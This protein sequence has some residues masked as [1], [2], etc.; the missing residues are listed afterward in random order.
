MTEPPQRGLDQEKYLRPFRE[1]LTLARKKGEPI[2]ISEALSN[3][4]LAY[5]DLEE[6][7]QGAE[8]FDLAI[9]T[10]EKTGDRALEARQ[11]G[12][13]G[14][15]LSEAKYYEPAAQCFE[16]VV[17]IADEIEDKGLKCDGLGNLA[18]VFGETGDHLLAHSTLEKALVIARDIEDRHR[19]MIHMGNLGGIHLLTANLEDASRCYNS[20]VDFARELGDR[21]SEAGYLNNIGMLAIRV[22]DQNQIIDVFE[23]VQNISQEIGDL[24]G[25][26]NALNHLIEAYSELGREEIVLT[27]T[28]NARKLARSLESTQGAPYDKAVIAQLLKMNRSSE[29]IEEL[30][31]A[32]QTARDTSDPMNELELL[33]NLGNTYFEKEM[34][35]DA[36]QTWEEAHRIAA[37][38]NK[39]HDRARLL[40]CL[41]TAYAE[42]GDLKKSIDF[43]N[44]SLTL[45]LE[46]EDRRTV[47]EQQISLA[48]SHRDLKQIGKAK[49]YCRQ[50]IQTFSEIGLTPF[51]E[52]ARQLLD[53]LE[54]SE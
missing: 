48:F 4:A 50:A 24:K 2:K 10:A 26:L 13:K 3:L 30:G 53:E 54:A 41:G 25:Q 34:V 18:M 37:E 36:L 49:D 8:T 33:T 51:E 17:S 15:A 46:I 12:I 40:G 31:D 38:L 27:Y 5:F 16:A 14:L 42:L 6:F 47:G 45:A 39:S 35:E 43:S 7:E 22:G 28:K 32:L 9:R 1:A 52:K 19:E 23:T 44:R 29:A 11:T 20:A 21:R